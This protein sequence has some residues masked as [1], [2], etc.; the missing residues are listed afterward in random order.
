MARRYAFSGRYNLFGDL[1]VVGFAILRSYLKLVFISVVAV[2]F[3]GHVV[4]SQWRIHRLETTNN[5]LRTAIEDCNINL[6]AAHVAIQFHR[7]NVSAIL[8]YYR[9]AR[10]LDLR[11]GPMTPA[12]LGV[13]RGNSSHGNGGRDNGGRGKNEKVPK[14]Q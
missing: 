8:E 12:D 13:L 11:D 6:D 10:C 3:I 7:D 4:Y 14:Q 2:G 1:F 9:D 5:E